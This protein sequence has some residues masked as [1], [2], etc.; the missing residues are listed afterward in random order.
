MEKMKEQKENTEGR[1]MREFHIKKTGKGEYTVTESDS[2]GELLAELLIFIIT[3][4]IAIIIGYVYL[5]Y[6]CMFL[7]EQ[8]G[9]SKILALVPGYN[10]YMISEYACGSGWALIFYLGSFFSFVL[11]GV[12]GFEIPGMLLM[13][14]FQASAMFLNYKF[15]NYIGLWE[16]KQKILTFVPTLTAFVALYNIAKS[17]KEV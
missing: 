3:I 2:G 13:I 15:Y 6:K 10:L 8:K 7:C 1:D 12:M 16:T 4:F 14:A 11:M 9:K 5:I 17:I